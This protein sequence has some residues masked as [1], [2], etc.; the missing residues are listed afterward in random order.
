[1]PLVYGQALSFSPLLYRRRER[2]NDVRNVLVG[3]VV[4]PRS[5]ADETPERLDS[6]ARRLDEA[7]WLAGERLADMRL[8]AL[9]VLV[10]DDRRT[11]DDSNTPQLHVFAGYEI[12]GDPARA[13]LG[14]DGDPLVFHCNARVAAHVAEELT[15]EGFDV[16]ETRGTFAP[17]GDP[18]RGVVPALVEPLRRFAVD[19]PI[20][21]IHINC[22]VE[23]NIS[24]LRMTPFG[25]ALARSLDLIPLRVGVLASGGLSGQPG[26]AMAGWIDDVLDTWVL[27]RLNTG[28]S[29]HLGRIFDVRSQLLRGSTR[30]IRLW[31]AAGAACEDAG[32]LPRVDEYI[33]LHHAAAG[34]GFMHW[35]S[36]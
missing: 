19:V 34:I 33:P 30:E 28:R 16:S 14:E 1:M 32:L 9:V 4:Q 27:G 6:Y 29:A 10:A 18:Q 17:A 25:E 2:W 20:V 23:P 35:R 36:D 13:D 22:H 26:D 7:F 11:F 31:A 5:A 21:P 8:D 24:G 15:R 3:D 12:W